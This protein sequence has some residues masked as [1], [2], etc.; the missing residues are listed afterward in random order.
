MVG[1]F[2]QRGWRWS[3]SPRRTLL[4]LKLELIQLYPM[5]SWE[6]GVCVQKDCE[7]IGQEPQQGRAFSRM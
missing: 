6:G 2:S 4:F 1:Q 7:D 3:P 5:A